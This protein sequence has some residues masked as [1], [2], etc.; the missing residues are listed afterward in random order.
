M[1]VCRGM[2]KLFRTKASCGLFKVIGTHWIKTIFLYSDSNKWGT[3]SP[4]FHA[5]Y[6]Y[7]YVCVIIII[8]YSFHRSQAECM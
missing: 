5:F 1:H 2:G 3:P 6:T 4:I 8:I 7:N